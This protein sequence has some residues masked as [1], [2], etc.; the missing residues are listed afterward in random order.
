VIKGAD[1]QAVGE[2]SS[3]VHRVALPPGKYTLELDGQIVPIELG[4]GHIVEVKID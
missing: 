3:G 1:G 4:E 2:I